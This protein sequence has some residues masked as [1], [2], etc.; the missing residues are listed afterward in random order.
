MIRLFLKFMELIIFKLFNF[1][2]NCFCK[3]EKKI[4]IVFNQ[5]KKIFNSNEISIISYNINGICYL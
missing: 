5:K 4:E 2:K 3:V 1:I